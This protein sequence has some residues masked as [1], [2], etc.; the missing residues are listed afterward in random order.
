MSDLEGIRLIL[1]GILLAVIGVGLM[2]A[3][4]QFVFF[5][6]IIA[7]AF[8]LLFGIMGQFGARNVGTKR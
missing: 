8:G 5:L 6:G 3:S 1:F 4:S 7:M 2:L